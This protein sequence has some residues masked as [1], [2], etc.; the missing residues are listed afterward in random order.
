MLTTARRLLGTRELSPDQARRFERYAARRTLMLVRAIV[1]VLIVGI[2]A[3][4]P[5]DRFI[6]PD[7]PGVRHL[8]GRMRLGLALIG[9]MF[10]LALQVSPTVRRAPALSYILCLTMVG[11]IA[12]SQ[13]G[14]GGGLD[15]PWF[16]L[17][18]CFPG[19]TAPLLIRFGWRL[20]ATFLI[21]ASWSAG[22][23]IYNPRHFTLPFG[24]AVLGAQTMMVF[25]GTAV[26]HGLYVFVQR[27]WA[28]R[29]FIRQ[30]F[31]RYFSEGVV[32]AVLRHHAG[33]GSR[34][35]ERVVTVLFSDL[36]GYS[37]MVE[38]LDPARVVDLLN[39][40]FAAMQV[41]IESC[42]GTVLEYIGDGILVVFGAPDPLPDHGACALRCAQ[43]MRTRLAAL[44]ET[45]HA[46][47]LDVLWR[48]HGL[49]R[50]E[51]RCGIHTGRVVAGSFGG[52]RLMKYG[53]IGDTVN[54]AA[55]LEA[56]NK[57][58][59]TTILLSDATCATLPA[60]LAATLTPEGSHPLKGR[61]DEV[62]VFSA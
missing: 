57:E 52:D 38:H 11:A 60:D 39:A 17:G 8:F 35:E 9:V 55:R 61:Q 32:D 29:Q 62:T 45:W 1:I 53:I 59:S 50:L 34:A 15:H 5:F 16:Y 2:L 54:V 48:E 18:Y 24:P 58:L 10:L 49:P 28:Q 36:R 26:G 44:N 42:S 14:M 56:L 6:V 43:A 19:L 51:A 21:T 37:T 22:F 27:N 46:D 4:W 13:L 33:Q 30:T 23:F 31:G 41:V 40:Y 25:C 20:G 3:F 47:G 7:D 12:G